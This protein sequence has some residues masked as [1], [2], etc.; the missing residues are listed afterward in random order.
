DPAQHRGYA[1]LAFEPEYYR[2]WNRRDDLFTFKPY[3]M[4]DSHDAR[5]THADIREL[6]WIHV[7]RD[8]ET[9]IGIS[10]VF[11]GVTEAVHLVDVINQTDNLVNED[12]EDRLGQPMMKLS[13]IRDYGVFDLF[14]LPGF[15]EREFPGREG[16]PRFGIP[17]SNDSLYES[18]AGDLHVDFAAR[19]SHSI[20][21]FD[22]GLAH[23]TGT[24]REP[25]FVALPADISGMTVTE[26][27][28]LYEIIN[29]TSLDLQAIFG[30]WL[31]KLEAVMRSG[32]GKRIRAFAGGYEYTFVGVNQSQVDVGIITEYLYDSRDDNI[33][34]ATVLASRP[35][36][37]SPFQDDLVLGARITLNDVASSELLASVII[38]LEGGGES[39][40]IEASR[41]FGD[42][43][44]VSLE[45]RGVM[46]IPAGNVLS[47]FE[48]DNRVRLELA[49]YF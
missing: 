30:G 14:M 9:N 3:L 18:A 1:S 6:S 2:E 46:N 10:K 4:L 31:L 47:S 49:R 44:K 29:Q 7:S 27:T 42:N 38:D 20:G 36:F 32:Q 11:W 15:R 12:G 40:N 34:P 21:A 39:Y 33:D 17:V 45:A 8:W 16:R 5:R 41:R 35:F 25:R 13:L 48:D 43:W 23:F 28:P 22:I 19:W 24:G 37:T 26:I